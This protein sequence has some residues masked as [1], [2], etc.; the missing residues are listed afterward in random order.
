MIFLECYCKRIQCVFDVFRAPE[1][2][3]IITQ[4]YVSLFIVNFKFAVLVYLDS[5]EVLFTIDMTSHLLQF[6]LAS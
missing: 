3:M 6:S 1:K 5:N 2:K 4:K